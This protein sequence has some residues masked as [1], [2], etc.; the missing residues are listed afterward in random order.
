MARGDK[1]AY[2]PKQQRMAEHIEEG[3]EHRGVA[4]KEAESRAWATVNKET[5]GGR[6]S[7]SGRKQAD[8]RV[9]TRGHSTSGAAGEQRTRSEAARKGWETRRQ[10]AA[11]SK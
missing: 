5:G 7:E 3:Y 4:S 2:T 10:N 9:K 6:R 1:T 11:G 8:T